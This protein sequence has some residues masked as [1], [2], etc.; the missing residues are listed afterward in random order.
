MRTSLFKSIGFGILT[1]LLFFA[2]PF[3]IFHVLIFFCIAG[4]FFRRMMW[5]GYH[6]A[7]A[8]GWKG[9]G[10]GGMRGGWMRERWEKMSPEEREAFIAKMKAH[11][12][13]SRHFDEQKAEQASAPDATAEKGNA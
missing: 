11:G 4:F 6:P 5:R 9:Y 12:C 10:P 2:F 7:Y 3:F 8:H 1:G 13:G